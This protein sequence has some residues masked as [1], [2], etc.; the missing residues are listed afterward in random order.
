[1]KTNRFFFL[2]A[3]LLLAI[4]CSNLKDGTYQLSIVSTSDG[5]GKWIGNFK[6]SQKERHNLLCVSAWLNNYRSL[7]GADNILLLDA[8]DNLAGNPAPFYYNFI[9]TDEPHLFPKIA[10][11]MGYDAIIPGEADWGTGHEVYDRVAKELALLKIP[12]LSANAIDK[13]SGKSYFPAYTLCKKNGV[14]IAVLG[15]TNSSIGD[16]VDQKAI[17]GI[18]FENIL[19]CA[20][21]EVDAVLEKEHPHLVV[22]A[23]HSGVGKGNST[24]LDKQGKDLLKSLRGVDLIVCGHDHYNEQLVEDNTFLIDQNS[25]YRNVGLA[26]IELTVQNGQIVKKKIVTNS[27][28]IDNTQKDSVMLATFQKDYDK[29]YQFANEPIGKLTV[30]L[31]AKEAYKGSSDY[32]NLYHTLALSQEQVEISLQAPLIIDGILPPQEISY[33]SL[34]NLYKFDNQLIVLKMTGQEIKDYLEKSYDNQL[35]D[36]KASL[37]KRNPVLRLKTNKDFWTKKTKYTFKVSPAHFDFAGGLI[38]TVDITRK[39]GN[40]VNIL[41]MADGSTF[42]LEKEYNTAITSYRSVGAGGLLK[43]AGLDKQE[44]EKR[45]VFRGPLY[46]DLLYFWIQENGE[47]GLKEISD[48][49]LVGSWKFIP[50]DK[51]KTGIEKDLKLIFPDENK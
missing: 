22:V 31:D 16:M 13:I 7:K 50:E 35:E 11:Y 38:Y 44:V 1:M 43:A 33:N 39:A 47:I 51:A 9:K 36:E 18:R 19:D 8:G 3:G 46:R 34:S 25:Y 4:S 15:F 37:F 12:V 23:V 26:E 32:M 21:K 27:P 14:K 29:I 24:D 48:S 45:I 17:S 49:R 41:S 2:L 28:R 6:D 20:Q 5:H 42:S 40:R 30:P 10:S